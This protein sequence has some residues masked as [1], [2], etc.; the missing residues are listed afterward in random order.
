ML[1]QL[2]TVQFDVAPVN[3][4]EM[5]REVG[6]DF[7]AKDIVGGPRPREFVGEADEPLRLSGTLYPGKFGGLGGLSTLETMARSGQPQMLVRGDGTVFGWY[8]LER[9]RQKQGYLNNQGIGREI[10]FEISLM[11]SPKAASSQAML[12][13]LMSLFA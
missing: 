2:G 13:T 7:A 4:A 5:E 8:F 11:K 9:L 10:T 1:Y 6:A 12:G 3:V